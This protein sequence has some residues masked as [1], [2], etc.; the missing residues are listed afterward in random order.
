MVDN[1]WGV[2]EV[3][4]K[5][6]KTR[7]EGWTF[8]FGGHFTGDKKERRGV[9]MPRWLHTRPSIMRITLG[10]VVSQVSPSCSGSFAPGLPGGGIYPIFRVKLM[11]PCPT[12]SYP[13]LSL[14]LSTRAYMSSRCQLIFIVA[15]ILPRL[16]LGSSGQWSAPPECIALGPCTACGGLE[17]SERFCRDTQRRQEYVCR[18]REREHGGMVGAEHDREHSGAA[19]VFDG[20]LPSAAESSGGG[21]SVPL[22][23]GDGLGKGQGKGRGTVR[24]FRSCAATPDDDIRAVS[25]PRLRPTAAATDEIAAVPPAL[26]P[27]SWNSQPLPQSLPSH[28]CTRARTAT[29]PPLL[30]ALALLPPL[31]SGTR[32]PAAQ[33]AWLEC[34]M[35]A[36]LGLSLWGVK[37]QKQQHQ[38]L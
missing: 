20:L 36:L 8:R 25:S 1:D 2:C 11:T 9:S 34:W 24:R 28:A 22:P 21:G 23:L 6:K 14:S 26:M 10:L 12:C 38:T 7:I 4:T 37:S 19:P 15:G 13:F 31:L 5:H 35:A 29:P 32:R 16:A 27:Y 17:G 3:P 18:L 30:F 33:V